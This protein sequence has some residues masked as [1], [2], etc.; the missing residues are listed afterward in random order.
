MRQFNSA[1]KRAASVENPIDIEF[2]VNG[3]TLVASPP[4][5][6]QLTMF[7]A[8]QAGGEA[9]EI[10]KAMLELL[11]AVLGEENYRWL[12]MELKSGVVDLELI[13]EIIEFLGE[14]WSARPTS[15]ASALS[16][17]R[18][19]TGKPSTAARQRKASTRST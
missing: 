19:S 1:A 18:T 17:S 2:E 14:T 7:M 10:A 12:E 6:G 15:P 4:S 13:E 11:W 3:T 9:P 16:P 8:A 5:S